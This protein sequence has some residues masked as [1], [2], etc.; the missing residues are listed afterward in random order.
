MQ[1]RKIAFT[2]LAALLFT[3]C[4]YDPEVSTLNIGKDGNVESYIVEEFA[5]AYYDAEEL[6]STVLEEIKDANEGKEEPV[7]ELDSYELTENGILK[8][9]IKYQNDKAYEDFNDE[10]LYVGLWKDALTN[11]YA[12]KAEITDEEY[13]IVIFGEK[14]NVK[15]PKNI[16]YASEGLQLVDKKTVTVTDK[17]KDIYY[18]I[19]E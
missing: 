1:K 18:I 10:T 14:V 19:Y 9:T 11:G 16:V 15:V 2:L 5:A 8:A 3:G 7:V 4:G 13:N 17:E 12:V 6:R